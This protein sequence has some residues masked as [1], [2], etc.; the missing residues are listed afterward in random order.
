MRQG[1]RGGDEPGSRW[2]LRHAGDP[3]NKA[4]QPEAWREVAAPTLN[5]LVGTEETERAPHNLPNPLLSPP[6]PPHHKHKDMSTFPGLGGSSSHSDW[7]QDESDPWTRKYN[8]AC[9]FKGRGQMH[10]GLNTSPGLNTFGLPANPHPPKEHLL[11][12]QS[13]GPR[14]KGSRE[15]QMPP[16]P[17]TL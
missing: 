4:W 13:W 8:L 17:L 11:E 16:D 14:G 3:G 2:T 9:L 7:N 1:R 5:K 12:G 6:S 15:T 10:R